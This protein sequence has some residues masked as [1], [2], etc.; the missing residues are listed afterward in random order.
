[1]NDVKTLIIYFKTKDYEDSE[2]VEKMDYM[3]FRPERETVAYLLNSLRTGF[4]QSYFAYQIT[5]T[6]VG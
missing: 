6:T 3:T 1:M 2:W 4:K 5:N